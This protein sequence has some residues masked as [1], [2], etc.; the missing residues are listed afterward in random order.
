MYQQPQKADFTTLMAE[1]KGT[2]E[3]PVRVKEEK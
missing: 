1:S 3:P 2:K